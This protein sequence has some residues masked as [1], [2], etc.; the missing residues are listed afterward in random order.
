[1][2]FHQAYL[3][4]ATGYLR[5]ALVF[6]WSSAQREEFNFYFSGLFCSYYLNLR[7]GGRGGG[8]GHW[9]IILWGLD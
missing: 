9:A 8:A 1:M 6:V 5:L 7:F 4:S 3:Q 2:L